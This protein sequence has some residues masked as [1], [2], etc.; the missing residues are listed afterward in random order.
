MPHER[1]VTR[2]T[3]RKIRLPALHVAKGG[4]K[5]GPHGD[6]SVCRSIGDLGISVS[7]RPGRSYRPK[8]SSL[9]R[10]HDDGIPPGDQV[11][12]QACQF[13]LVLSL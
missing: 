8:A 12:T 6:V 13:E 10:N 5:G 3:S 1:P 9:N 7:Y 2:D 11:V 4:T